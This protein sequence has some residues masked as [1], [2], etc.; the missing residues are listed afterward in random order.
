MKTTACKKPGVGLCVGIVALFMGRLRGLAGLYKPEIREQLI[1]SGDRD[2]G[3]EMTWCG[4]ADN[5]V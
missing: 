5:N 3:C 4:A 1:Y 2:K